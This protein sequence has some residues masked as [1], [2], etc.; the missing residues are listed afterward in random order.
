MNKMNVMTVMASVLTP[1]R[2]TAVLIIAIGV[3][4]LMYGSFTIYTSHEAQWGSVDLA[5]KDTATV[6]IPKWISVA[7]IVYG[8]LL[9]LA[10]RKN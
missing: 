4:C 7:A 8:V 2:I 6:Y 9:M 10:H 3:W 5:F 1:A